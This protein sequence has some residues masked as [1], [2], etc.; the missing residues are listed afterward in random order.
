MRIHTFAPL[1]EILCT[2][3]LSQTPLFLLRRSPALCLSFSVSLG[4]FFFSAPFL[5]ALPRARPFAIPLGSSLSY[6]LGFTWRSP[7]AFLCVL[8]LQIYSSIPGFIVDLQTCVAF[9]LFYQVGF[10]CCFY[11]ILFFYSPTGS[12][13]FNKF[14]SDQ[15]PSPL[16]SLSE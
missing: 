9:C 14:Y 5:L 12:S 10:F 8:G 7:M 6:S 16:A 4:F 11:F 3:L 2:L 13:N 1:S 15:Q